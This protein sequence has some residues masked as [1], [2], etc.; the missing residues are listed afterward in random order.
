[1]TFQ[2]FVCNGGVCKGLCMQY[3]CVRLHQYKQSSVLHLIIHNLNYLVWI[4]VAHVLNGI[5]MSQ[6][7]FS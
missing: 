6:F 2:H 5:I 1:M 3:L 4:T 7:R